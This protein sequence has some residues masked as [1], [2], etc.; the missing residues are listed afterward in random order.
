M[1]NALRSGG[2]G[3]RPRPV[4]LATTV[5][6]DLIDAVVSG[7][8]AVGEALPGEQAL[9]AEF[10]V[11]RVVIRQALQSLE[12]KGLVVIRQGHGTV[13]APSSAWNPL[14]DDV[15]DA[16]IRHDES[17]GVLENLVHVRVALECELAA[18]AA[19]RRTEDQARE[20]TTLI[21]ELEGAIGAPER[22]LALDL[23]FH[24][25]I[26]LMSG[27]DVGRAIVTGIH[28]HARASTRYSADT[29]TAEHLRRAQTGHVAVAD[30]VRSGDADAARAAMRAH[31]IESWERM[32]AVRLTGDRR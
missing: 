6:A 4:R 31:I 27:N 3:G 18:V 26:M 21:G 13:V 14:D 16:R 7:R 20:L 25:R 8:I 19:A 17:L 5:V 29:P 22:Y 10:D 30:A 12:Q 24:E 11:S 9:G 1:T 15:L 2:Q 32:K 28:G 23:D